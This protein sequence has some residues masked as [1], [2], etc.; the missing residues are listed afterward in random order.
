MFKYFFSANN[1][2]DKESVIIADALKVNRSLTLLNLEILCSLSLS[3]SLLFAY[4]IF[5]NKI[6]NI[7][8]ILLGD[9]LKTNTTLTEL[10]LG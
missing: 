7:T 5:D 3:L 2:E 10:N 8:G 6:G 4:V 1:I 9:A